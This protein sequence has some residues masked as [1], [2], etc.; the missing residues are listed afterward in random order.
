[1]ETQKYIS[2]SELPMPE[3]RRPEVGNCVGNYSHVAFAAAKNASAAALSPGGNDADD[4]LADAIMKADDAAD[5]ADD[6]MLKARDAADLGAEAARTAYHVGSWARNGPN[7]NREEYLRERDLIVRELDA[8]CRDVRAFV[9]G[10]PSMLAG[11][12]SLP[13]RLNQRKKPRLGQQSGPLKDLF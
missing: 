3:T 9:E 13:N 1:M 10:P 7:G 2:V 11:L 4:R 12:P 6:A 8:N 5:L